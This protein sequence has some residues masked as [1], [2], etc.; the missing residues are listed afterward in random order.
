IETSWEDVDHFL[1]LFPDF[2]LGDK[3][4][5]DR[6]SNDMNKGMASHVGNEHALLQG[7]FVATNRQLA[8]DPQSS[9][10]RRSNRMRFKSS[11]LE[12]FRSYLIC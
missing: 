1:K 7:N 8:A 2:N 4:V 11:K 5:L 10:Y 12:D 9:G 3:V 6:E